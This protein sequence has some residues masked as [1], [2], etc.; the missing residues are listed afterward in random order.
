MH[1][2]SDLNQ[3]LFEDLTLGRRR[4]RKKKG[5]ETMKADL[6]VPEGRCVMHRKP[7]PHED[8]PVEDDGKLS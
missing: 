3:S 7:R 1:W 8:T 4:T 2:N 5:D 6:M